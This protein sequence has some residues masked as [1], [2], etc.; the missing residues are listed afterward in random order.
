MIPVL[1]KNFF[2]T[3]VSAFMTYEVSGISSLVVWRA[4]STSLLHGRSS[5]H[6]SEPTIRDRRRTHPE[7]MLSDQNAMGGSKAQNFR[8]F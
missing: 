2:M 4:G 8:T 5:S 1:L 7:T 3:Y 6:H